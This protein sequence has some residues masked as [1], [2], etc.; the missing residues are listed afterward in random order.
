MLKYVITM[1]LSKHESLLL[2][3]RAPLFYFWL[4]RWLRFDIVKKLI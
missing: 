4:D 3:K 1:K 2:S